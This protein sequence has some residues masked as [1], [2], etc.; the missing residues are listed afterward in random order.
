MFAA[1]FCTDWWIIYCSTSAQHDSVTSSFEKCTKM[2]WMEKEKTAKNVRD[3]EV[4]VSLFSYK[5]VFFWTLDVCRQWKRIM[6]A[7]RYFQCWGRV[8]FFLSSC[9]DPINSC[10]LVK[11]FSLTHDKQMS[12]LNFILSLKKC[13]WYFL[14]RVFSLKSSRK[15]HL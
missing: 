8:Q 3:K 5:E 2:K 10:N 4:R 6:T 7:D 12:K 11:L 1:P 13:Q 9:T 15:K 14:Q